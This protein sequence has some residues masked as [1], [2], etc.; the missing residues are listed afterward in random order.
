VTVSRGALLAAVLLISLALPSAASTRSATDGPPVDVTLP[1]ISGTAVEGSLLVAESGSW[2]GGTPVVFAYQWLLCDASGGACTEIAGATTQ[3]H[4]ATA[5]EVGRTVRVRVTATNSAGAAEAASA[6]TAAIQAARVPA[7]TEPPSVSGVLRAGEILTTTTGT[8]SGEPAPTYAYAWERCQAASL[9]CT[10]ITGETAATYRLVQADI[11]FRLRS[12][13]VASNVAG[14]TSAASGPTALVDA[15]GIVPH[16]AAQPDVTGTAKVGS[17]LTAQ[18]GRWSGTPPLSYAFAWQRCTAAGRC[19]QIAGAVNQTYVATNDDVGYRLRAIVTVSN[20]FGHA[21]IATNLTAAAIAPAG[22]APAL[23]S[24]PRLTGSA[25]V[26]GVLTTTPGTWSGASSIQYAYGWLRCDVRGNACT[27]VAGANRNTYT[28]TPSDVGHTIRARVTA[29][30]A[31]VGT[32]AISNASA[33]VSAPTKQPA[34]AQVVDAND[35][36][37]PQRLIIS[38]VAFAPSHLYSRAPFTAR[39]RVTDTR[40]YA[41]RNALVYVIALPYGIVAPAGETRTDGAGYATIRLA[42]TKRLS[43][44]RGAIVM[45]VRARSE[46]GSVLAGVSTR[47][48]VQVLVGR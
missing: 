24:A 14:S 25:I 27:L 8:W 43:L 30:A 29:S 47:R 33:I 1:S 28:L 34:G 22:N 5:S 9:A 45:F 6:P 3:S 23:T 32:S 2:S 7:N 12:V 15:A 42:P 44:R 38:G 4:G 20:A 39:F 18:A 21:S 31:G 11:G 26:A 40:G 35:V 13:V 46:S 36:Q 16:V 19:T 37:P 17:R 48:L 41:V 10:A